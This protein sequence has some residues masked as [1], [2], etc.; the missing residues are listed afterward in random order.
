[1]KRSVFFISDGTGIT[2]ETLGHSLLSQF[3]G[4][5]FEELTIPYVDNVEKA[6]AAVNEINKV[7]ATADA[8]PIIIDTIVNKDVRE[9]ISKANGYMMDVFETFVGKLETELCSHSANAVGKS[10]SIVNNESYSIRID[11]VH[12][13]LDNDDGARTRPRPDV[14]SPTEYA[15]HVRDVHLIFAERVRLMLVEDEPTFANWDQDITALEK[16]Y[17]L[18]EPAIVA[19]ELLDAAAAVA[20]LYEA[21]PPGAWGRRGLR[22]NGSEFTVESIGRYH[23]HDLVHHTWD[24]TGVR[25]DG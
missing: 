12:F 6:W 5:E 14:W 7:A 10:H 15:A 19:A 4:I 13:A 11:A 16:R 9:V 21:V 8:R 18:A 22:S 20:D 17:D 23:L 2:A 1:M 25:W 3:E 24:V